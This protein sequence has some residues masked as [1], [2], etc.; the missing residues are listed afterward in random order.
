[1]SLCAQ[2]QPGIAD[3]YTKYVCEFDVLLGC[4]II[5]CNRQYSICCQQAGRT[6][7]AGVQV[8]QAARVCL[9]NERLAS[10]RLIL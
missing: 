2:K 7:P 4:I 1:M 9:Y 6:D 5:Q 10:R 3:V 8:T